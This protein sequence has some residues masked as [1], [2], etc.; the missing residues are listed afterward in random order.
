MKI[1]LASLIAILAAGCTTGQAIFTVS[2]VNGSSQLLR[3]K[4]IGTMVEP[5]ANM[6]SRNLEKSLITELQRS[7]YK[8]QPRKPDVVIKVQADHAGRGTGNSWS[9]V[10]IWGGIQTKTEQLELV[11]L[12]FQA[13]ENGKP[14]WEARISGSGDVVLGELQGGCIRELLLNHTDDNE[15]REDR[16]YK[17][18]WPPR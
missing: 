3:T 18:W 8:Y 1:I 9:Y 14:F 17:D 5:D 13:S 7:K 12:E 15:T 10:P 6:M 11:N 4:T 2:G 16:C